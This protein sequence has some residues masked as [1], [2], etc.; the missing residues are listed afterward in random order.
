MRCI[1]F[2]SLR[3]LAS[4]AAS[5]S[6]SSRSSRFVLNVFFGGILILKVVALDV[7]IPTVGQLTSAPGC[8]GA[9]VGGS[10][11]RVRA[12]VAEVSASAPRR[13][14]SLRAAG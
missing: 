14:V 5:A 12:A 8:A 3:C 1:S 10:S 2:C 9:G 13:R 11:A 6:A 4:A 7:C